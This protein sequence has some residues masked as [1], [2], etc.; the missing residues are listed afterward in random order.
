MLAQRLRRCPNISPALTEH[1]VFSGKDQRG[2]GVNP[3]ALEAG[4]CLKYA[5][6]G[7][8]IEWLTAILPPP[9]PPNSHLATGK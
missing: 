4:E 1:V 6:N 8:Q 2:E 3:Q 9:P 7:S 5:P